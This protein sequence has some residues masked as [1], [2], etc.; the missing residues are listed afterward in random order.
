MPLLRVENL[1]KAFHR[2]TVVSELSFAIEPGHCVALI[3]PNGAGKTTTL[4]M[5][6]GLLYP[7]QGT[8]HFSGLPG[9]DARKHIGYLPQSPNFYGWMTGEEFL[10]YVAQLSGLSR[11]QAKDKSQQLMQWVGLELASTKR[12]NT[13]SGGMKQRLGIAQAMV[14][15]PKLLI[16]DEPVSALDPVGRREVLAM[17][18]DLKAHTTILFSTHV[19]H[20]AEAVSDDVLILINGELQV[21]GSIEQIQMQYQAQQILIQLKTPWTDEQKRSFGRIPGISQV[22]L[23]MPHQIALTVTDVDAQRAAVLQ[24]LALRNLPVQHVDVGYTS[25]EDIFMKVMAE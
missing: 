19:L 14:N 20:D 24:E 2:N 21:A 5:L 1:T 15:E 6:S 10:R 25:L 7:T 4:R 12:I 17:M 23:L 22:E 18:Q 13:Y 16:L 8:M 11:L 3:G 9:I